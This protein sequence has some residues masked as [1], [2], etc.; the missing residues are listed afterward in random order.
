MDDRKLRLLLE[1]LADDFREVWLLRFFKS[2]GISDT[3]GVVASDATD[4]S[5]FPLALSVSGVFSGSSSLV[6]GTS[7]FKGESSPD[8]SPL[9]TV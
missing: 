8:F 9:I 3:R 7:M 6:T 1:T 4:T 5:V 2:A